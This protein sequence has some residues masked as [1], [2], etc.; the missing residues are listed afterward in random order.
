M[1][2]L[3][4]RAELLAILGPL[5]DILPREALLAVAGTAVLMAAA[6]CGAAVRRPRP[7]L[8][9]VGWAAGSAGCLVAWA[10]FRSLAAYGAPARLGLW[11][12]LASLGGFAA[13]L[14]QGWPQLAAALAIGLATT[15]WLRRRQPPS[16]A[17]VSALAVFMEAEQSGPRLTPV[18]EIVC[19]I[20]RPLV[21]R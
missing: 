6:I 2:V 7:I 21:R 20:V 8:F 10:A 13:M 14:R 3:P 17:D 18:A 9:L 1:G 5:A 11:D 4:T 19:I 12:P 15:V 16:P